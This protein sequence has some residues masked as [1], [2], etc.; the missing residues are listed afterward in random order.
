MPLTTRRVRSPDDYPSHVP[1]TGSPRAPDP[2]R[3]AGAVRRRSTD[4]IRRP[5]LRTHQ[6]DQPRERR[7]TGTVHTE[8]ENLHGQP[9]LAGQ[10][11]LADGIDL[12]A[13][14]DPTH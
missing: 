9:L 5:D 6:I 1:G 13:L 2:N 11:R 4:P 12:D 7:C 10:R 3:V 14:G 8:H